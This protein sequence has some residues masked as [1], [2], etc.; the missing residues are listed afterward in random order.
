MLL[1]VI[2]MNTQ[3]FVSFMS[4]PK[5]GIHKNTNVTIQIMSPQACT[6]CMFF[7]CYIV[8]KYKPIVL[9]PSLLLHWYWHTLRI[10]SLTTVICP[11]SKSFNQ[12]Q[13]SFQMKAALFESC[14]AITVLGCEALYCS[15]RQGPVSMRQPWRFWQISNL[16]QLRTPSAFIFSKFLGS[17]YQPLIAACKCHGRRGIKQ[18]EGGGYCHSV[19]HSQCLIYFLDWQRGQGLFWSS[20]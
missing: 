1:Q 14:T 7:L 13:H 18:E 10:P 8:F 3:P 12:C 5:N 2:K 20:L 9:Y 11:R 16:A 4:D 19:H 17:E 15:V 6:G